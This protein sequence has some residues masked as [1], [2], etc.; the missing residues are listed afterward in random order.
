[1][2]NNHKVSDKLIIKQNGEDRELFMSFGLLN[3]LTKLAPTPESVA[4]FGLD[5][6]T[7]TEVRKA[8]LAERKSGGKISR[9][10]DDPDEIEVSIE[11]TELMIKWAME[12]VIG[13][14]IRSMSAIEAVTKAAEPVLKGLKSSQDGSKD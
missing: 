5:P 2:S 9:P 13:F 12:H 6:E 14:F 1:M 4:L 11:D 8:I 7:R 10:V 3:E